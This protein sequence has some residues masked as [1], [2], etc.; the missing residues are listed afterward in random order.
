MAFYKIT[1]AEL[2]AKIDAIMEERSQFLA[3]IE[4]FVKLVGLNHCSYSNHLYFGL[5]LSHVAIPEN[6]ESQIDLTKWKKSKA[7]GL[8][9]IRLLP[10]KSNKEFYKL[11]TENYPNDTFSY[12][13]LLKL[14]ITEDYCPFTKG[15]LG[16]SYKKGRPF[17]FETDKYTP[18]AGAVE[19]LTIEYDELTKSVKGE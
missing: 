16:Y 2:L 12:R 11:W 8:P 5:S 17:C 14:I 6:E 15:G 10:R 9:Y 4:G 1:D 13:E 7:K 19:I 18:V 3:K